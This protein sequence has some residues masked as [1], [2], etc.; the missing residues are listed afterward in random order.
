MNDV[1]R[2]LLRL[3]LTRE[4]WEANRHTL[5][6]ATFEGEAKIIFE[7]VSAGHERYDHDLTPAEIGGL[8]RT[9]HPT[10]P[11]AARNAVHEILADL[12]DMPPLSPDVASDILKTVWKQ[13]T[14][15]RIAELAIQGATGAVAD[16]DGIRA[17]IERCGDGFAPADD[18]EVVPSELDDILA[19]I[20]NAPRWT[21]NVASLAR[22]L[23][24]MSGGELLLFLARP[25][26][27]KSAAP[28]SLA[29][30]PGGWCEQGAR[31]VMFV[32]EEPGIRTKSRGVTAALQKPAAWIRENREQ[33]KAAWEPFKDHFTILDG[34]PSQLT[35]ARIDAYC[36]RHSPDIVVIDQLDKVRVSGSFDREDQ[37]LRRVYT[38]ARELA[39]RRNLLVVGIGQASAEAEGRTIVTPTMAEGSKTGK[40]AEADAIIGIGRTPV[41]TDAT[42]EPD[43]TR[44]WTLGKNKISA[45]TGT[46]LVTLNPNTT[47][48][49]A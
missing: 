11:R 14:F 23:P 10:L 38:E 19:A 2:P 3:L 45:W 17:I 41:S 44:W 6:P 9:T 4:F 30:A 39:K 21:F 35:M 1:S 46:I 33:A 48:Y 36:R 13:Q 28:V 16:L 7:A 32:N 15:R 31:V 22:K 25:E 43:W 27:G 29:M 5:T 37:R 20:D 24:G 47:T 42:A 34:D 26:C 18:F 8:L 12:S 49:H 40:F